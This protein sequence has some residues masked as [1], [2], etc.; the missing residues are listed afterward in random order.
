M[1]EHATDSQISPR[2]HGF[3]LLHAGP[4]LHARPVLEYTCTG[5]LKKDQIHVLSIPKPGLKS[6]P[7][8][9][10]RPPSERIAFFIFIIIFLVPSFFSRMHEKSSA[11]FIGVRNILV[12]WLLGGDLF[13]QCDACSSA[14]YCSG[15][16]SSWYRPTLSKILQCAPL[17]RWWSLDPVVAVR[18]SSQSY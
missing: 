11:S 14:S 13:C 18:D 8:N 15:T 9:T 1:Q 16:R 3:L 6:K 12:L 4:V 17:V 7:S 2:W 10:R 5:Q